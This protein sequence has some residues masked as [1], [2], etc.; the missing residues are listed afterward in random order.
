M[1]YYT[2]GSVSFITKEIIFNYAVAVMYGHRMVLGV[3]L[4]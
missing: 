3:C 4:V 2:L 1:N